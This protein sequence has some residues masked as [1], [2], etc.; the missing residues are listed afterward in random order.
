MVYILGFRCWVEVLVLGC[1]KRSCRLEFRLNIRF[2]I[3]FRFVFILCFELYVLV[4]SEVLD[5]WLDFRF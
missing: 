2:R 1:L 5:L 3:G 4:I